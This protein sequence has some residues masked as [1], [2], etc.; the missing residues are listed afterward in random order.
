MLKPG[1]FGRWKEEEANETGPLPADHEWSFTSWKVK[2]FFWNPKR[3]DFKTVRWCQKPPVLRGRKSY[4]LLFQNAGEKVSNKLECLFSENHVFFNMNCGN[5][6]LLTLLFLG[7]FM[8]K[9]PPML[10]RQYM[11]LRTWAQE[12]MAGLARKGKSHC[13]VWNSHRVTGS[14]EDTLLLKYKVSCHHSRLRPLLQQSGLS[15]SSA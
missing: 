1:E 2:V 4:Q 7:D 12:L 6:F 9:V 13:S 5:T 3:K 8:L 11:S 14:L 15:R 10:L